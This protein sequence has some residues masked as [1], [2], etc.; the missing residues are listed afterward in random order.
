MSSP[1]RS[2]SASSL[3]T[4]EGETPSPDRSRSVR[5]PTGC[6][7]A[8]YSSTTLPEDVA[9][10]VGEQDLHDPMVGRA[11]GEEPGRHAAA[12]QPPARE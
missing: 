8:T 2:S 11:S 12:E 4:V 5:E 1:S 9:L 10:P 3:R 6:P 7:V